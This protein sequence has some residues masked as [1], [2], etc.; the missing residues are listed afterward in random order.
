MTTDLKY[1]SG[2]LFGAWVIGTTTWIADATSFMGFVG[3]T[4]GMVA[5]LMLVVIR[6]GDF[7]QSTPIAKLRK[8]LWR[9]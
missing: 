1:H 5:G 4:A 6:W 8:L 2:K 9:R 3:A 7:V